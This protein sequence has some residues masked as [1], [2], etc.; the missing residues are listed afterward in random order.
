MARKSLRSTFFTTRIFSSKKQVSSVVANELRTIDYLS[1]Q[2]LRFSSRYQHKRSL[3]WL[4]KFKDYLFKVVVK[5]SLTVSDFK[6]AELAIISS[7]QKMF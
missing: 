4:L 2:F 5:N 6:R 7:V 1:N 3:A